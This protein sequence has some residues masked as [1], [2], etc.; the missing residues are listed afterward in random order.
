M[1]G[2]KVG[3]GMGVGGTDGGGRG[4]KEGRGGEGGR[5]MFCKAEVSW[6]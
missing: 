1:E 2:G 3:K 4:G 5:D 6:N